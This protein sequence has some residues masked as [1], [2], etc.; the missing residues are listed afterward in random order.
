MKELDNTIKDF[1]DFNLTEEESSGFLIDLPK[2]FNQKQEYFL[3]HKREYEKGL[4]TGRPFDYLPPKFNRIIRYVQR[5]D[6][7]IPYP[8][9]HDTSTGQARYID[10]DYNTIS[11][12]RI[13]FNMY[14]SKIIKEST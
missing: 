13:L 2:E 11:T 1:I 5:Q 12:I 4:G 8:I 3:R 9:A 10:K 14:V 7:S 6:Y